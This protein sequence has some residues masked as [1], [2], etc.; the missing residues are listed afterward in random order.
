MTAGYQADMTASLESHV[1]SPPA[2]R[3]YAIDWLRLGAILTVFLF[4]VCHIFDLAPRANDL[5]HDPSPSVRNPDSS[6]ALTVYVFFVYQWVMQVLFLLAGMTAWYSLR[7][8]TRGQY[9][10]ERL[11]RLLVP[12]LF[13][14][15]T[16]IPWNG[17]VSALNHASFRGSFWDYL[18]VHFER[19]W[20]ALNKPRFHHG[21]IALYQTS[22]H[23]WFLAFLTIFA[24]LAMPL[25]LL[26]AQPHRR[27]MVFFAGL[28]EKPW[29]LA[30]LGLPVI[31]I[32]LALNAAFP[33][34]LDWSDTLVFLALFLYGSLF[35]TNV[36][37]TRAIAKQANAWLIV[38]CISF[39]G[40]LGAHVIGLLSQWMSHPQYSWSYSG[41]Q[42]LVGVDTW[43]WVLAITGFGLRLLNFPNRFLEYANEAALPF[44][45]L[46]QPFILT[47]AFVVVQ[48]PM[49]IG[50]KALII[51]IAAFVTTMVAYEYV[52][53]RRRVLRILFGMKQT[54]TPGRPSGTD[55][56]GGHPHA[57]T[58]TTNHP[59]RPPDRAAPSANEIRAKQDACAHRSSDSGTA[60]RDWRALP[61]NTDPPG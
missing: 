47:I 30:I 17:Y 39:A 11:C 56:F 53:R 57:C 13:G 9:V 32:K 48:Y 59:E 45:I 16:L 55:R 26:A 24:V 27:A 15:L 33:D 21:L 43:A 7:S 42:L 12:F 2:T 10:R 4:H 51:S 5:T 35:M 36:R 3:L 37:F 50:W 34:Y 22:W 60:P 25:Q 41:Y 8:R 52:V 61:R 31:A 28:A 14:S 46:H 19:M 6:V 1:A 44:Y 54:A 38:G 29:G 58:E 49:A 40:L 18:P 20:W 23:L